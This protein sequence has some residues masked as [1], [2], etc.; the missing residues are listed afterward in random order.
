MGAKTFQQIANGSADQLH[1]AFWQ[2]AGFENHAYTRLGY[3]G[4]VARRFDDRRHPRENRRRELLQ[5]SP[6]RKVERVD[7]DPHPETRCQD[8][9]ADE[10]AIARKHF[11]VAIG[12]DP[13]VRQL[14][15][16]LG[17]EYEHGADTT[18]DI[19]LGVRAGGTGQVGEGI[20]LLPP[21]AQREG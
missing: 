11:K 8:M 1:G 10:A 4:G 6:D 7:L 21:F 17:R 2:D 20:E 12:C 16:R 13:G 19:N 9:L 3:E 18:V 15:P 5:H 14:A